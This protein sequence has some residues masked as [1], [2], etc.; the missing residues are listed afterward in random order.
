MRIASICLF[1]NSI[2][3]FNNEASYH[4]VIVTLFYYLLV[5]VVYQILIEWNMSLYKVSDRL[6]R[7]CKAY[8][9]KKELNKIN[10]KDS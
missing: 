4:K 7:K 8:K 1:R 9:I 6:V 10:S 2:A 5:C 3:I